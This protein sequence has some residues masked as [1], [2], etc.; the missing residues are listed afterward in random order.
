MAEVTLTPKHGKFGTSVRVSSPYLSNVDKVSL[1]LN[2]VSH[3]FLAVQV[4]SENAVTFDIG[5][6][7]AGGYSVVAHFLGGGKADIGSF[8]VN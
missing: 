4:K 3:I 5:N 6:I 7:A 1:H 2:E 8:I